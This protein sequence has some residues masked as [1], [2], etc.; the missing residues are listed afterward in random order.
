MI[1]ENQMFNDFMGE[2]IKRACS[3]DLKNAGYRN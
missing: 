1:D 3:R 2:L